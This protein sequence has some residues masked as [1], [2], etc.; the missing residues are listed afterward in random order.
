MR[1]FRAYFGENRLHYRLLLARAVADVLYLLS[2]ALILFLLAAS[3][4]FY[5]Q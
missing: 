4:Q 1:N 5:Q 3:Y 2:N